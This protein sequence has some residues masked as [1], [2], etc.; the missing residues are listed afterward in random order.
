MEQINYPS[1]YQVNTRV[2]LTELSQVLGRRATLDDIPDSE[3]D[4]WASKGFNWIWMLSVWQTGLVGQRVSRTYPQWQAEFRHT[5]TDLQEADIEGSGFAITAYTVHQNM[6]GDAA[7]ARLRQRLKYRNLKLMLDFVPN[8]TGIDHFW[9]RENPSYYVQGNEELLY[10]E[11]QNYIK[12]KRA[13]GD[14]I[15]AHG[16]DPYFSGWP[17]TLQLNYGSPD[18][19]EAQ[20]AEIVRIA[21]QC[22]GI[23]CD[24]AMLVLPEI[25]KRTWGIDCFPF[26]ERA[27]QSAQSKNPDFKFMAEVYWDMEWAL[28]QLGF[29]YTYD[30]RLYDRLHEGYAKPVRE[31][32]YAGVDYQKHMV[33]FLENHDEARAADTFMPEKHE[34][35][36]ILTYFSP[37]MRFFHQGQ[38]EGKKLRISPHL[39]RGPKELTDD[40][41]FTFY[42]RIL[43][44]LKRPVFTQGNWKLLQNT[45]A[46]EGNESHDSYI[47][48]LWEGPG[49]EKKLV[50]VNFAGQS[51]QCYV[52]LPFEGLGNYQWKLQDLFSGVEY[53]YSGSDIQNKGLYFDEGP[54]KYYIF[55]L[56]KA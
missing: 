48:Y 6:G 27:I 3:L 14:I 56:E 4:L 9:V 51:S 30:K 33:R 24:M 13:G 43:D 45:P 53:N 17:D 54:W 2:M 34:A 23:R 42:Q 32:L 52:H 55:R 19:Q 18:C 20:I 7:L 5:L 31:H 10:R 38:F 44:F 47:S 36:A 21:G 28:Q 12:L 39:V 11:P 40:R 26:W 29:E 8:H 16:R 1:L 50:V 22:D 46:W 41:L 35:A 49:D 25:F 15:F 37:G